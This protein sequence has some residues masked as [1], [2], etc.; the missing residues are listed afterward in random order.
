M[1]DPLD[2]FAN[3]LFDTRRTG[4]SSQISGDP[5]LNAF[6]NTLVDN[7][8]YKLAASP[9][10]SAK[11]DTTTWKPATTLGVTAGQ[12]FLGAMLQGLGQNWEAEQLNKA[13]AIL[14]QMME[15]P[16][17]VAMPEG[18]SSAAFEKMRLA[19]TREKVLRDAE[20]ASVAQKLFGQAKFE[21]FKKQLDLQYGPQIKA[22]EKAAE[23]GVLGPDNPDLPANKAAKETMKA[24]DDLRKE[25]NGLP[26]VK[27]FSTVLSSANALAGALKDGGKVSDQELTR[28][29]ILMIEPGLAVREGEAAAIQK[30]QSIPEALKGQLL[31]ALDG[32]TQFGEEARAGVQRLAKRA[33][34][35]KRPL[36]EK[37][38][39]YYQGR[40]LERGLSPEQSISYLGPAPETDEIFGAAMPSKFDS[41]LPGATPPASVPAVGGDFMGQKIIGVRKVR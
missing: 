4:L 5:A 36:Y 32:Q 39:S 40:A 14:P 19:A 22:A 37:A 23:L 41:S 26:D 3:A 30:S 8:L 34:E 10:L 24:L 18:I 27:T 7:N 38:L 35:S 17:S 29:A 16:A 15:N 13:S 12:A 31:G 21:D 20:S 6:A 11:F 33:Y 28:Y 9:L 2:I 1:A 25:F